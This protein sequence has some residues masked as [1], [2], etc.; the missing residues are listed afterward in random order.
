MLSHAEAEQKDAGNDVEKHAE[1]VREARTAQG[2]AEEARII[3]ENFQA[4]VVPGCEENRSMTGRKKV[5]GV[6]AALVGLALGAVVAWGQQG[7]HSTPAPSGGAMP[8]GQ[9]RQAPGQAAG[10][11]SRQEG[12]GEHGTPRDWKFT[13]PKGGDPV[14]GRDAFVKFECFTCHEVKGEK[15]PAPDPGKVGPELSAMA[16]AHPPEYFAEAIINP[17]AVIVKGRGYEATDGSSKMPSY[18]DDLTVQELLD[19]VVYLV[20]LQ[21]P[22]GGSRAPTPAPGG[23][24]GH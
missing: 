2:C 21:P 18:N 24:G 14:K 5:F 7:G 22:A 3:A 4:M 19:L 10:G 8:P 16:G 9:M 12:H 11:T 20:N 17:N 23:H 1:A 13:L 6:G 15:F